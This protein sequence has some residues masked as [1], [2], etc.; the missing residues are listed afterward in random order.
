MRVLSVIKASASL[1]AQAWPCKE[2]GWV[3]LQ[4]DKAQ[5]GPLG[6]GLLSI[7]CVN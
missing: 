2:R 3:L 4:K 6:F 1:G 5:W 7:V